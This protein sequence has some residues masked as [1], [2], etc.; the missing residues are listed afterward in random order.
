[1]ER[2]KGSFGGT[3]ESGGTLAPNSVAKPAL[4]RIRKPNP[5][6]PSVADQKKQ[7]AQLAEMGI[8]VPEQF[9]PEMAMAGEWSVISRKIS[10]EPQQETPLSIGVKRRKIEGQE[11]EE[12]EAVSQTIVKRGWGSTTKHFPGER[13]V[14]LDNLLSGT[15]SLGKKERAAQPELT[16]K[17]KEPSVKDE[18]STTNVDPSAGDDGADAHSRIES[19]STPK[20]EEPGPKVEDDVDKDS[21]SVPLHH[22]PK[23]TPLPVFKKRKVK[24]S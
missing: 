1:V 15:I 3:S 17:K 2:L 24:V 18:S 16:V 14:D 20:Q 10:D 5:A 19:I 9:R 11:D 23:E 7:W 4:P 6:A 22:I 8:K 21:G 12:E 13:N